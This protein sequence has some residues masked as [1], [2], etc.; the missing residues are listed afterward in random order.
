MGF[1]QGFA[2]MGINHRPRVIFAVFLQSG[3]IVFTA[4]P[5]TV[6]G[7]KVI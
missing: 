7:S 2:D 6:V 4:D 5:V 1:K 3:F